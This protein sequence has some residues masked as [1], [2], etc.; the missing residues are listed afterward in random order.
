MS[1]KDINEKVSR[2]VNGMDFN[3]LVSY[4]I[5]TNRVLSENYKTSKMVEQVN[6]KFLRLLYLHTIEKFKK[7]NASN[8][9]FINLIKALTGR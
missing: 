8:K 1:E 9:D 2:L 3:D 4:I 7:Q 6:S 5:D